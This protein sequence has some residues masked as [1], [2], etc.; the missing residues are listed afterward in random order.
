MRRIRAFC[1]RVSN[2]YSAYVERHGLGV[3]I[4]ACIAVIIATAIWTDS[5]MPDQPSPP[6]LPTGEALSAAEL[7]QQSLAD[8]VKP[9][10]SPTEAPRAF[11]PPLERI[12]VLTAFDATRLQQ[13]RVTGVWRLH[14]AVDLA[15]EPGE[16]I[17][18]MS[19]GVVLST[20]KDTVMGAY[21]HIEHGDGISALYGGMEG[22]TG[23]RAGDPVSKGQVVGFA[24]NGMLDETDLPSHIHLRVT[25][26]GKAIDPLTLLQ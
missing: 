8:A 18:S 10:A 6:A 23:I 26:D 15:A 20:G 16:Q 17:R 13:S 7:L 22:L 19:G 21:V 5:R 1:R 2:G 11:V 3:I 4:T 25:E 9:T 14:D 12:S 24:G